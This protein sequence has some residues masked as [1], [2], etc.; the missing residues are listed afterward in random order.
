MSVT[1]ADIATDL[2]VVTPEGGSITANQW[3]MWIDDAEMLIEE[4]RVKVGVPSPID[5]AKIDYAVRKAVVA[6][7]KKPDDATQIT[8]AVDDGSTS[9]RYE[10]GKGMITLDDW[11]DY[12]GLLGTDSAAFTIRPAGHVDTGCIAW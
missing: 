12:L 6:H 4:R 1:T 3:E 8:V 10:S 9:R 7:V 11:W 2:G 5:E